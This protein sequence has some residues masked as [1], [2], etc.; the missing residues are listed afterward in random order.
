MRD[1][2]SLDGAVWTGEDNDLGIRVPAEGTELGYLFLQ[3][4]EGEVATI[5]SGVVV[6]DGSFQIGPADVSPL[7]TFGE[8]TLTRATFECPT[9]GLGTYGFR[10]T[11]LEVFSTGLYYEQIANSI[12]IAPPPIPMRLV[13]DL[14]A[15]ARCSEP[16]PVATSFEVPAGGCERDAVTAACAAGGD[17][18]H[19][20]LGCGPMDVGGQCTTVYA[21]FVTTPGLLES[22]F[23]T[24]RFGIDLDGDPATGSLWRGA[25]FEGVVFDDPDTPAAQTAVATYLPDFEQLGG[26]DDYLHNRT[27]V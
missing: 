22:P 13:V 25:E 15:P 7:L 18:I 2:P 26:R 24:A 27:G 9:A 23:W 20:A 14:E 4:L 8:R 16:E 21:E 12:G 10:V 17:L 6:T 1:S 5:S 11:L 3:L 19:G